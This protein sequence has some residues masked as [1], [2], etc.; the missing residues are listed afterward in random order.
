VSD[1]EGAI[2]LAYI[3]R[4][5]VKRA[6]MLL[7][8]ATPG[9]WNVQPDGR[10]H[11]RLD[12]VESDEGCPAGRGLPVCSIPRK[13]AADAALI[14]EMRNILP[15]LLTIVDLAEGPGTTPAMLAEFIA[16]LRRGE[17]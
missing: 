17:A 16:G 3:E 8:L 14:A 6:K 2:R 12:H 9:P 1:Y 10:A 4:D 15:R 13:R 7:D 5:L 11:V